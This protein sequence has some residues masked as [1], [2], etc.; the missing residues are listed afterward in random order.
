MPQ[1]IEI[2]QTLALLGYS[3]TLIVQHPH[4]LP[5]IDP[6]LN[7]LLIAQLEVN[8]VRILTHTTVTQVR[9][10][11]GEKWV[12]AGDKA[13]N[14]EA[15]LVA[16]KQRP[17]LELLNL[18]AVGVKWHQHKLIVNK[19]LQTTNPRIYACGDILG[20][21]SLTNIAQYEANLVLRNALF[22]PKH[23]VNYRCIPWGICTQPMLAQIGLTETEAKRQYKQS[24]FLVI[25]QYFKSLSIAQIQ[26]ETTGICKLI[27]RDNGEILGA[28]IFGQG[29]G[30]LINIIALAMSENI[31]IQKLAKLASIYPTYTEI[32]VQAAAEW[33]QQKI[34]HNH[35]LQEFL[36]SFF[37][38]RRDWNI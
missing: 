27:V 12:Q 28:S 11:N 23:S 5:E 37:H 4:L 14:T 9:E 34:Q 30:E 13:I 31:Y 16:T 36:E 7:Q 19:K 22:F 32:L 38:F 8:G 10:I 3:V 1:S 17:N 20:G 25:K 21:Y 35:N 15:I 18:A 29:A 24:E 33:H 6:E 26:A 2:A